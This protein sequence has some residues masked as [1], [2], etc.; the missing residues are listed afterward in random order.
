[1]KLTRC[2]S[3]SITKHSQKLRSPVLP[4]FEKE[5]VKAIEPPER[6]ILADSGG[7]LTVIDT[8]HFG[9]TFSVRDEGVYTVRLGVFHDMDKGAMEESAMLF[10]LPAKTDYE[11][12]IIAVFD[13]PGA[14]AQ[15]MDSVT[16]QS[17]CP[18]TITLVQDS[19]VLERHTHPCGIPI[20]YSNARTNDMMVLTRTGLRECTQ[21]TC[22][23]FFDVLRIQVEV[24]FSK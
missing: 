10:A 2:T 12:K 22:R 6:S 14:T 16:L 18:F 13:I 20:T 17:T 24:V 11:Q 15:F 8:Q 9:R 21:D 7:I 1:M 5:C 4:P 23:V 3:K 19:A